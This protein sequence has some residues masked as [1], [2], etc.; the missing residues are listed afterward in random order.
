MAKA[1]AGGISLRGGGEA[2][3]IGA[4]GLFLRSL[5]CN[6]DVHLNTSIADSDV[7]PPPIRI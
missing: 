3:S 4:A 7:L 2:L 5:G 6:P 1:V